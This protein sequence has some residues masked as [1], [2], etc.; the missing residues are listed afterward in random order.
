[1]GGVHVDGASFIGPFLSFDPL[2]VFV[3]CSLALLYDWLRVKLK[4]PI[5]TIVIWSFVYLLVS[6]VQKETLIREL[7]SNTE[8]IKPERCSLELMQLLQKLDY[9]VKDVRTKGKGQIDSGSFVQS[10]FTKVII[11]SD[12]VTSPEMMAGV[13]G[14]ELGHW[15]HSHQLID[16]CIEIIIRFMTV[17]LANTLQFTEFFMAMDFT[18][19]PGIVAYSLANLLTSVSRSILG[20]LNLYM[21][22]SFEYQADKFA[23]DTGFGRALCRHMSQAATVHK[24][25]KHSKLYKL[26]YGTHPTLEERIGRIKECEEH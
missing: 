6:Q 22:R 21:R 9:P 26:F 3:E 11:V 10:L 23:V 2:F 7:L 15:Y 13:I 24:T 14:H 12:S 17:R 16:T 5:N 19:E 25:G 4:R 1:M 18:E 8:P 20:P